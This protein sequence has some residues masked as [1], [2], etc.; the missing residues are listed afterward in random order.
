[1]T[2]EEINQALQEADDNYSADFS[3][4]KKPV[5]MIIGP[6]RS[7]STLLYQ[8]LVSA[9][10]FGYP[11]NILA[12]FWLAPAAGAELQR[13]LDDADFISDYRSD[14]GNTSGALEPHEWGWFWRHW[15]KLEAGSHLIADPDT[16]DWRGLERKLAAL[17]YVLGAPLLFKT[18]TLS[19]NA[20]ILARNWSQPLFIVTRRSPRDI[21][22]S[23]LQARRAPDGTQMEER[24]PIPINDPSC[25]GVTDGAERTAM[26]VGRFLQEHE[27]RLSQIPQAA[28]VTVDFEEIIGDPAGVVERV[29]EFLSMHGHPVERNTAFYA[30]TFRLADEPSA[31]PASVASMAPP[32]D[33]LDELADKYF[34]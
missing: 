8:L 24:L 3:V 1:M 26:Q 2:L 22:Q 9:L 30:P 34:V 12:R 13:Q 33:R 20:D 27:Q 15:L 5:C 28:R 23:T 31:P 29:A 16:V 25:N 18:V 32:F 7:G 11:S 10:R 6:S 4:P 19:A 17:E 14:R 21:F